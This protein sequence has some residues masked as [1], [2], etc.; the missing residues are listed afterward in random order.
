[1]DSGE[2][3]GIRSFAFEHFIK[4]FFS[5]VPGG[6]DRAGAVGIGGFGVGGVFAF[7]DVK[8]SFLG[9]K[10]AVAGFAGGN[11]AVKGIYAALHAVK[12]ILNF[13]DTE[14]MAGFVLRQ[15]RYGPVKDFQH[16]VS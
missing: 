2:A 10:A 4:V 1:M 12:E 13:A 5:D 3:G 16:V 8:V 6:A 15:E 11:D 14:E 9:P 7:C